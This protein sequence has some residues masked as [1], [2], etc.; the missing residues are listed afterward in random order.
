LGATIDLHL[1]TLASDGRLTPTELIQLVA[2]QGLKTISI[3]DHDSTEGLAEAYEAAKEFPDLRIIPGIEMSADLPGNEVHVLGYFLDYHDVEF[4]ASLTE[5]RRGRVDRAQIMVEKLEALGKPVDWERVQHFAGDGSVGRPHIALAMVEAGYF[6]EPKEAFEEY[7]GND[8]L[9]YYDRPKLNPI[10][11]VEMITRVGGVPVLAHPT[12][13]NDMEGGIADHAARVA[14]GEPLYVKP[15]LEFIPYTYTPLYYYACLPAVKLLGMSFLPLRLVSF[16]ASL[17]VLFLLYAFVRRETGSAYAGVLA[18]GMFAASYRVCGDWFDMARPDSL[19][20]LLLLAGAML[21]RFRRTVA[22]IAFAAMLLLLSFLTK[23]TALFVGAGLSL[24]TLLAFRGMRR[25]IFPLI[26][27]G[28]IVLTTA[29]FDR[30]TDGWYFYYVFG[31]PAHHAIVVYRVI[32]Y[33]L[34]D[35]GAFAAIGAGFAALWLVWLWRQ[36]RRDDAFFYLMLFASLAGAGWLVRMRT[37][38]YTNTLIPAY[39]AIALGFGMG[40]DALQ[41]IAEQSASHK[42][43]DWYLLGIFAVPLLA[44][45]QFMALIYEPQAQ[46]PSA[47]DRAAGDRLVR[48]LRSVDGEV[49][50]PGHGFLPRLAGKKSFAQ[51][52]AVRDILRDDES[53]V[54]EEFRKSFETDLAMVILDEPHWFTNEVRQAYQPAGRVF[55][56][57]GL[58]YP[59]SGRPVRPELIFRRR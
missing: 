37:G 52:V 6:K 17:G 56:E 15:S 38:S 32:S 16:A 29:L 27:F 4:Q 40:F 3:T 31:L 49:Y 33:W 46:L 35:M 39:A 30:L 1:H 51:R 23:Q 12:F 22:G 26:F 59:V 58:F 45:A 50:L 8:G 36:E 13:M 42:S 41:K 7:L 24:Y 34:F 18:T 44:L 43:G 11:S 2:K 20:L 14:S 25:I 5:F 57:K 54:T 10:E 9:A 53:P 47:A 19:F 55:A 28:G 21:L 48:L